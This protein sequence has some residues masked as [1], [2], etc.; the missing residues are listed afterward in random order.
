MVVWRVR[1]IFFKKLLKSTAEDSSAARCGI[2]RRVVVNEDQ[3]GGHVGYGW[4]EHVAWMHQ[5]RCHGA[6]RAGGHSSVLQFLCSPQTS[7]IR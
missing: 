1:V 3:P 5:A 7:W 2:T 6:N 4:P